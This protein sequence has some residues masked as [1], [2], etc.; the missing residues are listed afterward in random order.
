MLPS[1]PTLFILLTISTFGECVP[2]GRRLRPEEHWRPAEGRDL[3]AYSPVPLMVEP[4]LEP[5]SWEHHIVTA[6]R[7]VRKETKGN[8]IYHWSEGEA[9]EGVECGREGPPSKERIVGGSEATP[10][11][12]PWQAAIFING[13]S[14]CGGSIV[15]ERF[16]MTA[17]HCIH[18]GAE[19]TVMLG[20]HNVREASE[21]HRVEITSYNGY[22]HPDYPA[23]RWENDIALIELPQA[24]TFNEYILP[25]CIPQTSNT[26]V[27]GE[28]ASITGWGKTWDGDIHITDKLQMA[29]DI[30]VM[31]QDE[32]KQFQGGLLKEMMVCLSTEDRKGSCSGDSGG[33]MILKDSGYSGPGQ[34]WIQHGIVSF[35]S[36]TGCA[37]GYPGGYTRV[38]YYHDWILS[39]I[40]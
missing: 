7:G 13:R 6:A 10:N 16:V 2:H 11:Q 35:G 23:T 25:A 33:P 24:I 39:E 20:A 17:A 19:Y 38:A 34:K 1:L 9:Q 26:L 36:A 21:P 12:W 15:S 4:G 18:E 27:G 22:T 40:S 8:R 32:C 14:F 5:G 31:S 28:R 30:R 37:A 3:S 29:H